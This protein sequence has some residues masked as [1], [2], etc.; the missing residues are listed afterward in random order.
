MLGG[1]LEVRCILLS[2]FAAHNALTSKYVTRLIR[3]LYYYWTGCLPLFSSILYNCFCFYPSFLFQMRVQLVDS[4]Y[5]KKN[6]SW[7]MYGMLTG[8]Y[9][10]G[11][12]MCCWYIAPANRTLLSTVV[13]LIETTHYSLGKVEVVTGSSIPLFPMGNRGLLSIVEQ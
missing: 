1:S 3:L 6:D 5:C 12:Y 8:Q 11:S 9:Q 4:P 7:I 13:V 2:D 10:C